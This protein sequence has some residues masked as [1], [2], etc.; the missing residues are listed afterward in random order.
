MKIQIHFPHMETEPLSPRCYDSA[1]RCRYELP[2]SDRDKVYKCQSDLWKSFLTL[3]ESW[4]FYVNSRHVRESSEPWWK[5]P[6]CIFRFHPLEKA[7]CTCF[8][9][10][11][12][13]SHTSICIDLTVYYTDSFWISLLWTK[14]SLYLLLFSRFQINVLFFGQIRETLMSTSVTL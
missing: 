9:P 8:V 1:S 6:L 2:L 14:M 4:F 3:T 12:K 10:A 7:I 5:L 13:P 11:V